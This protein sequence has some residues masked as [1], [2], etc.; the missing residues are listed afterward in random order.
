MAHADALNGK[1]ILDATN[2]VGAEEMCVAPSLTQRASQAQVY[3]A[4]NT[5]GWENFAEP[6]IG[7]VQADLFFCGSDDAS[8]RRAV[9]QLITDV[10]LRPVYVGGLDQVAVVDNLTRLWF[11]LSRK[12]GR[13]L[14]FRM[15]TP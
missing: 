7:G 3:R 12:M 13:H 2:N 9:E 5:L 8:S 15:L 1:I 11:A 4:F 14:A 10:G 6:V